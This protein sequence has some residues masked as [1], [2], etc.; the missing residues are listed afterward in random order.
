MKITGRAW[1][2]GSNI[3][4]DLIFPKSY[5]RSTYEP[6]EMATHLMAGIDLEFPTKATSG[7]II[8][9][10]PNFGCGSSREE[11]AAAMKEF[12]IGA[13]IA[14]SF[15]RLFMRNGINFGLPIV[16]APDIDKHV[17]EGDVIEV[18]LVGG[19]LKNITTGFETRLP[20]TAPESLR[21]MRDGGIKAYTRRIL[22]E[23][24]TAAA[25]QAR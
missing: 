19:Q 4:T 8:V 22:E 17:S 9:A 21:M 16:T 13:V 6:G 20:P 1:T 5:F 12:G 24:K 2:F 3:N 14:P 15:S 18:D 23:R 10:G 25:A 7:D 11:A